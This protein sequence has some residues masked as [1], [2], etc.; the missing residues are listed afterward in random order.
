TQQL[1]KFPDARARRVVFTG[2]GAEIFQ[3]EHSSHYV[4]IAKSSTR[5][6]SAAI[7][8]SEAVWHREF[9]QLLG[10]VT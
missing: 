2:R 9:M 7:A 10:L 8:G 3:P 6:G 5:P 4:R 1:H